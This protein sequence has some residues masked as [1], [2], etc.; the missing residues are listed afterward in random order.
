MIA[1]VTFFESW[2]VRG[3]L[4]NW[5]VCILMYEFIVLKNIRP[6]THGDPE[7]HKKYPAFVREDAHLF[8]NRLLYWS[9]IWTFT[10]KF[11]M[12]SIFMMIIAIGCQIICIGVDK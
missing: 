11:I 9:T 4:L 8:T 7:L 10:P 6:I 5:L 2:W 1:L 3:F 12:T